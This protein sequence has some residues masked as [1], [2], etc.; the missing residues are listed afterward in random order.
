MGVPSRMVSVVGRHTGDRGDGRDERRRRM[1]RLMRVVRSRPTALHLAVWQP[2]TPSPNSPPAPGRIARASASARDATMEAEPQYPV[3]SVTQNAMEASEPQA[4]G[5]N[6]DEA[7]ADAVRER[8]SRGGRGGR[9]S[10]VGGERLKVRAVIV[11]RGVGP[12]GGGGGGG[13]GGHFGG[14][15]GPAPIRKVR[16]TPPT[17]PSRA[18]SVPCISTVLAGRCDSPRQVPFATSRAPRILPERPSLSSL[19]PLSPLCLSASACTS[20]TTARWWCT[21]TARMSSR[22]P[23]PGLFSSTRRATAD[24]TCGAR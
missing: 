20:A 18:R 24:T 8:K 12:T 2:G 13:R 7:I 6:L 9:G 15:G 17:I 22:W 16:H 19:T 21:S 14:R 10:G 11:K 1:M 4:E 3:D 5:M 23:T